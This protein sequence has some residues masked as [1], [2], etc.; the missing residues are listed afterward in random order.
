MRRVFAPLLVLLGACHAQRSAT[1]PEADEG[2]RSMLVGLALPA[3]GVRVEAF[4]YPDGRPARVGIATNTDISV[5]YYARTLDE[6]GLRPGPL[7]DARGEANNRRL[8]LPDQLFS[9]TVG[10]SG[11]STWAPRDTLDDE[12]AAFRIAGDSVASCAMAGGCFATESD[13]ANDSCSATCPEPTSPQAPTPPMPPEAPD[14]GTCPDGWLTVDVDGILACRPP[15][16]DCA[17]HQFIADADCGDVGVACPTSGWPDTVPNDRPVRYVDPDAGPDG[18]GTREDP[19]RTI[20]A[21]LDGAPASVAIALRRGTH[22]DPAR[23][24]TG[25][26]QF[27]GACAEQST[28]QLGGPWAVN[29][30]ASELAFMDVTVQ[31]GAVSASGTAKIVADR[32][33]F[34]RGGGLRVPFIGGA[35]ITLNHVVVDDALGVAVAANAGTVVATNV[36]IRDGADDAFSFDGDVVA[37]LDDVVVERVGGSAVRALSGASTTVTRAL[38][39]QA[40]GSTVRVDSAEVTLD[41]AVIEDSVALD[42]RDGR[43]IFATNNSTVLVEHSWIARVITS[44]GW[45]VSSAATLRNVLIRDVATEP[46]RG[47]HGMAV[48][49]GSAATLTLDHVD[50]ANS[51]RW[52]L[53]VESRASID[54]DHVRLVGIARGASSDE[55]SVGIEIRSGASAVLDRIHVEG[56]LTSALAIDDGELES[57]NDCSEEIRTGML[58]ITDAE[59]LGNESASPYFGVEVGCD[60]EVA[61]RRVHIHDI[62]GWGLDVTQSAKVTIDDFAVDNARIRGVGVYYDGRITGSNVRI[63]DARYAV[64]A[65][66]RGIADLTGVAIDCGEEGRVGFGQENFGELEIDAFEAK[67]CDVA[68]YG[69]ASA[70]MRLS[71]GYVRDNA[72]AVETD[73]GVENFLLGVV[74]ENNA[75]LVGTYVPMRF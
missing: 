35:D 36:V 31:R 8:P 72:I 48:N 53:L 59:L 40:T 34:S 60:A 29:G 57:Q 75:Q 44:A 73:S 71:D 65:D 55:N 41:Y 51:A 23:S 70:F 2:T 50:I 42:E 61:F 19:F 24:L 45:F 20:D 5:L 62:R 13:A 18:V 26:V 58:R 66:W 32:A 6:L 11:L 56:A 37:T 47:W 64:T 21:A 69:L 7:T 38:F 63:T 3:G 74:Y 25:L 52:G 15:T 9:A 1:F 67:N 33:I 39:T 49:A 22:I 28:I 4:V 10:A 16:R 12:L 43:A 17:G 30:A 68:I 14:F 46:D 27:V 54:A